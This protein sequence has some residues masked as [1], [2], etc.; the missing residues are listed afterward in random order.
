[1]PNSRKASE[2]MTRHVISVDKGETVKAAFELMEKNDINHLIVTTGGR[3]VGVLSMRDI[4]DGLGSSRF[5]R[6]PARRIYVSALMTEPPIIINSDFPIIEAISTM[7]EKEI[8]SLPVVDGENKPIGILTETD[9]IKLINSDSSIKELVKEGYPKIMPNE[10]IVYARSIML[11]RGIRVLPAVES[12]RLTGLIT[13]KNLAKAFLDVRENV[14]PI[15]MD[16]VVRRIVVEDVMT[17]SPKKL[18]YYA[19]ID[20]AKEIFL[21]SGLPGIP[22]VKQDDKVVGV[23]ERKSLLRFLR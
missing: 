7:I 20:S 11:E 6:I 4:M 16:N 3:I 10:R 21:E 13:E 2:F 9:V 18:E 8:G 19:S 12:S 17:E 5:Q 23:L 22:V 1:M 14:D 15:Y